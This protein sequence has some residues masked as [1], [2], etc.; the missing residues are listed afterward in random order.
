MRLFQALA[1]ATLLFIGF[2]IRWWIRE[3]PFIVRYGYM[4]ARPAKVFDPAA[5]SWYPPSSDFPGATE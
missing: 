1:A 4:P 2:C 5:P 3:D